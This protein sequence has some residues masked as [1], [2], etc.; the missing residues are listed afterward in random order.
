[1]GEEEGNDKLSVHA[2]HWR[3]RAPKRCESEYD[4][5]GKIEQE[6]KYIVKD[7]SALAIERVGGRVGTMSTGHG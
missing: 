4:D 7:A 6:E 3:N 5:E 2:K 1:V